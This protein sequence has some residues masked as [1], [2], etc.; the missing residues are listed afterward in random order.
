LEP[1]NNR[2]DLFFKGPEGIIYTEG[3]QHVLLFSQSREMTVSLPVTN[4]AS[5]LLHYAGCLFGSYFYTK[6]KGLFRDL[7]YLLVRVDLQ[8]LTY[9]VLRETDSSSVIFFH[10]QPYYLVRYGI[11]SN[12]WLVKHFENIDE[13]EQVNLSGISLD[14]S[15]LIY[16]DDKMVV[17]RKG[18]R[19]W[20]EV[21]EN[22]LVIQHPDLDSKCTAFTDRGE[23]NIYVAFST[24]A[25][26]MILDTDSFAMETVPL[27][28]VVDIRWASSEE[29]IFACVQS[30]ELSVVRLPDRYWKSK[31]LMEDQ[32]RASENVRIMDD[33]RQEKRR[34][35]QKIMQLERDLDRTLHECENLH[36]TNDEMRSSRKASIILVFAIFVLWISQNIDTIISILFATIIA[37]LLYRN[38]NR[39]DVMA[40]KFDEEQPKK[41]E[42]SA[43]KKIAE[44]PEDGENLMKRYSKLEKKYRQVLMQLGRQNQAHNL[45]QLATEESKNEG[46]IDRQ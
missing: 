7:N 41:Q 33:L 13:P 10:R 25:E 11:L 44:V 37:Y 35:E 4:A 42:E 36:A 15:L 19:E 6:K 18:R 24:K 40:E 30:S 31:S 28:D 43:D 5:P 27:P 39:R 12:T 8:L 32:C 38:S 3:E 34:N 2:P 21:A 16:K 20:S 1:L 46:F 23:A 45:T 17:L 9:R 26:L 22:V 14:D 29:I